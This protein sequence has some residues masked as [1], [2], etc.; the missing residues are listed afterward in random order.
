MMI[1]LDGG[2]GSGGGQIVRS[3]LA[4]STLA[5]KPFEI[6]NIRKGKPKPGLKYQH[7][8]CI[9]ALQQL[10]SAKADGAYLGSESLKYYPGKIQGKNIIIDIRTAGSISLLLQ[11][12]LLPSLF[13]DKK[14]KLKI[15]GGTDVKWAMPYDFFKEVFIPQLKK[16]ADIEVNLIKRGYFPKGGGEVDIKINPKYKLSDFNRF[17]EFWKFLKKE[18]L[19]I[20]L[21]DPGVLQQIKGISHASKFLEKAQVAER[22]TQAAKLI[23]SKY[24]C[25]LNI[26]TE[27]CDV[28]S[29]GSGITLYAI[30]SEE[31]EKNPII[32]GADALG[33]RGKKA[34][35][36]GKEAAD[37]LIKQIDSLTAVDEHMAD[38]C[39]PFLGL[40]GGKI[41]V[42]EITDHTK[43]N[44]YTTEKFLGKIFKIDEKNKIIS[45]D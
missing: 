24:K 20:E 2:Y 6:N 39:I 8:H 40:F 12:I 10:C 1:K 43:T 26:R 16:Y 3:A 27:Y 17:E 23:L 28:Y 44:I 14:T 13:A 7:L 5:G 9:K 22:Q 21:I 25:P 11:A 38:N 30:F 37:N 42:S 45:V 41:N 4:L 32:L 36:V 29:P 33:E 34:E 35:I 18:A 15:T 19:K 31:L